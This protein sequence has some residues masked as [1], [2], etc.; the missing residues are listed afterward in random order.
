M[1]HVD[2]FHRPRDD[3]LCPRRELRLVGGEQFGQP[4]GAG[5][6]HG[7]FE[8]A[9]GQQEQAEVGPVRHRQPPA[10]DEPEVFFDATEARL[11]FFRVRRLQDRQEP[12]VLEP[13][14]DPEPFT[15]P[16]EPGHRVP[17]EELFGRGQAT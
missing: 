16:F 2:V 14:D 17:P 6:F 9:V 4:D 11:G 7:F 13:E 10:F 1:L 5:E 12:L 8:S 3:L 15:P